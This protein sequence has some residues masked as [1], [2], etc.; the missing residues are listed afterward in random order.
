MIGVGCSKNFLKE[1]LNNPNAPTTDQ[2]TPQ[3][4]LPAALTNL[5]LIINNVSGTSGP[6]TYEPMAVWPGYWNYQAGYSF[7]SVVANYVVTSSFPQLWDN[8]YG[9]LTNLQF[10]T[11][12]PTD[13]TMANQDISEILKA[14]CFQNLVDLYNNIPYTQ[15]LQ[16]QANFYPSYDKGSDI[17]DSLT[18]K[19]DNAMADI[20]TNLSDPTVILPGVD[21]VI[22][23]GDMSN[24]IL[25]ANTVKLRLLVRETNVTSKASYISSEI[26]KTA[27][28][29]YLTSDALVNPGYTDA[30][31]N[32]IWAGFG[33]SPQG[34]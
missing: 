7:N 19:L 26:A 21:D 5:S 3:A 11:T 14:V 23:G 4:V 32:Q 20:N 27:S 31:P 6:A 9:V 10:M 33:V 8:Y 12:I 34:L 18:E 13:P 30:K 29:G 16:G 28:L 25:F 2:A 17:Y 24:W 15:A 1:D 22:F